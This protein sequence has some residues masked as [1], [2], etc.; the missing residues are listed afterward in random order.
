MS[1]FARWV[2][3]YKGL[4][5]GGWKEL[6]DSLFMLR[7][8][9]LKCNQSKLALLET[10]VTLAIIDVVRYRVFGMS[11]LDSYATLKGAFKLS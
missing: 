9:A 11:L 3:S 2:P 5:T 8:L 1:D 10:P 4:G 6:G 7:I